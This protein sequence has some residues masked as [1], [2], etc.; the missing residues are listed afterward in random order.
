MVLRCWVSVA[1][2]GV[3]EMRQTDGGLLMKIAVSVVGRRIR[4]VIVRGWRGAKNR[5]KDEKIQRGKG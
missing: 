1:S 3:K 2:P 5:I 4:E